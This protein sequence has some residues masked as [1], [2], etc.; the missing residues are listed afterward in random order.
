[1]LQIFYKK[2]FKSSSDEELISGIVSGKE[3]AFNE[4]YER[5]STK[6]FH[7]FLRRLNNE[8]MLAEDFLQELF[9]KLIHEGNKFNR[10]QK[11]SVWFYAVATNMCRNHWRNNSNRERLLEGFSN[12][13]YHEP[14]INEKLNHK[15]FY[16]DFEKEIVNLKIEDKELIILRFEHEMPLKEIAEVLKIPE[17]TVK[18]R[19]FYLLKK[20]GQQ[21]QMYAPIR[22]E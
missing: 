18:S 21:L 2:D 11:F 14:N 10:S 22:N 17:G 20:L 15:N 9:L 16:K 12:W 1:L 13:M 19:L 5:Y 3:D 6:M 8:Q 7:Y 4:L